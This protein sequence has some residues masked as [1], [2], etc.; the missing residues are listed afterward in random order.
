MQVSAW[1]SYYPTIL[2]WLLVGGSLITLMYLLNK[3]LQ[4]L[5]VKQEAARGYACVLP[6][7]I[8]FLI[9]EL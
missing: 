4:A 1:E 3:G 6:W 2:H 9:V 8:G 5:G 7:V